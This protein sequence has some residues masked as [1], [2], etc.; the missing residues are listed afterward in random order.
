[1]TVDV[2]LVAAG[3]QLG[4]EIRSRLKVPSIPSCSALTEMFSRTSSPAG[5]DPFSR[6]LK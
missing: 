5:G 6:D 4:L 1:M 3:G 2:T